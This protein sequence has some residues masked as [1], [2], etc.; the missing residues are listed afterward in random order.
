MIF[1]NG[2]LQQDVDTYDLKSYEMPIS[3]MG[4][5]HTGVADL[6]VV[7]AVRQREAL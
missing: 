2:E 7:D 4:G 1:F 6:A 5:V 3:G